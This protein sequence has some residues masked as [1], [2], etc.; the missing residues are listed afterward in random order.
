V[1]GGGS[2]LI[3]GFARGQK[4]SP[5]ASKSRH[6]NELLYRLPFESPDNLILLSARVN[7][8]KALWIMLDT[9]ASVSVL[10]VKNAREL[11][12]SVGA[13]H[14][15]GGF[16][17]GEGATEVAFAKNVTFDF[18]GLLIPPKQ[19]A[20]L[21]L[22]PVEK[23]IGHQVEGIIGF[24]LLNR[25]IAEVDYP[26][27]TITFCDPKSYRYAGDGDSLPIQ[28]LG[29]TPYMRASVKLATRESLSGLFVI[30]SGDGGSLGLNTPF[31]NKHRLL[32]DK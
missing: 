31:V 9:G 4:E 13:A 17:Q 19:V 26:A 12:I 32:Q 28:L 18:S 30:D 6:E 16:G 11:G 14:P 10:S 23:I 22:E 3:K 5:A 24:D 21:S 25:Y 15:L 27:K 1:L 7:Q 20:V 8:S 29:N 2:A